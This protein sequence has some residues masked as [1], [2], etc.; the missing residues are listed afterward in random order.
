MTKVYDIFETKTKKVPAFCNVVPEPTLQNADTTQFK[1]ISEK[2]VLVFSDISHLNYIKWMIRY[3]Y[4]QS[5]KFACMLGD[6]I[7]I[8]MDMVSTF[9]NMRIFS[10]LASYDVIGDKSSLV[11]EDSYMKGRPKKYITKVAQFVFKSGMKNV[12]TF[13][14][15]ILSEI[16]EVFYELSILINGVQTLEHSLF[17]YIEAYNKYAWFRA[18]L[19]KPVVTLNDTPFEINRKVEAMKENLMKSHIHPLSDLMTMGVK[20]NPAQSGAFLCY[21]FTPNWN[22]INHCRSVIV[23]GYLNGF[24]NMNDFFLN[25][26]NGRIATIKGKLDVKDPGVLGKEITVGVSSERLNSADDR[27]IVHDCKAKVYFPIKINSEND[28]EFYR[29][30]YFYDIKKHTKLGYIDTNRKDLIGKD[31]YIRTIM[32]CE[33]KNQICEECFGYNAKLCQDT[34]VQKFDAYTYVAAFISQKMQGVISVKH[35]LAAKL[36]PMRVSYGDIRDIDL[37]QFL[38]KKNIIDSMNFD[39]LHINKK[40][41]VRF[42]NYDVNKYK[43]IPKYQQ[44]AFPKYE[45]G[46]YGKL[47]INDI[48]FETPEAIRKIDDYTYRIT[49]PN[50]SVI[51]ESEDLK[52]A[53]SS[54]NKK[55]IFDHEEL[56]NGKTIIEQLQ[57]VY[58]F[59]KERLDMPSFIYYEILIHALTVDEED[60][61]SKVTAKTKKLIFIGSK[62][63][64]NK[65]KNKYIHPNISEG[66]VHG[67]I[68]K[69]FSAIKVQ[70]NPTPFDIA[71][72]HIHNR[73]ATF[74]NI[75]QKLDEIISEEFYNILGDK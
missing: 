30:K 17:G 69:A 73:D 16:K 5:K 13:L 4:S 38:K 66:L 57:V 25:D 51:S 33:C 36:A 39:I 24:R 75:P 64:T 43:E 6:D 70:N 47:Y 74:Y 31:L 27:K 32:L 44:E 63:F 10:I 11:F 65:S 45:A 14:P 12:N 3:K 58:D 59:I 15:Y 49:I 22:D 8:H 62:T 71:Y 9:I 7:F 21:G 35:H 52:E 19:D 34:Q 29:Y 40:C 37:E 2:T 50:T 72:G 56:L 67:Y 20:N 23:G 55:E 26:N 53:L 18:A 42:E 41:K 54:H 46:F 48:E 61:A 1:N 68:T 60:V 28:L